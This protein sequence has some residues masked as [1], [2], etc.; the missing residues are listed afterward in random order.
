MSTSPF[1]AKADHCFIKTRPSAQ[2]PR[3]LIPVDRECVTRKQRDERIR[4][5]L[6]RL[7]STVSSVKT[8]SSD[9]VAALRSSGGVPLVT[10]YQYGNGTGG[11]E[12]I[13]GSEGTCDA[14]GYGF[15]DTS[16]AWWDVWHYDYASSYQLWGDCGRFQAVRATPCSP[17]SFV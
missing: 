6:P 3:I 2:N 11:S 9:G 14:S 12:T 15:G 7:K 5:A 4:T 17:R 1:E 16:Y 8:Q 10:L 13:L